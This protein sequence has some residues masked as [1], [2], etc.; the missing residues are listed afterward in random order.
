MLKFLSHSSQ[1]TKKFAKNLAK[2]ILARPPKIKSALILALT[3]D[4]GSGKTTFIQG[5]CRAAGVEGRIV[6]PTFVIFRRYK[7]IYHL[8]CH[9]LQNPKNY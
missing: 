6:S 7:N 4:L 2:K 5:F 8:D 9:R 1:G 3:G